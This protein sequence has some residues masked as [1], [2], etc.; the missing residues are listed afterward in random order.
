MR[1]WPVQSKPPEQSAA[2]KAATQDFRSA[3]ERPENQ[4]TTDMF[5]MLD[6]CHTGLWDRCIGHELRKPA[7][8][9][10]SLT[11]VKR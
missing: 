7:S 3:R 6:L 1:R 9:G 11:Q 2:A 8:S 5:T 4:T 10:G